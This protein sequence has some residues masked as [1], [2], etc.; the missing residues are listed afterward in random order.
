M[1]LSVVVGVT[2]LAIKFTAYFITGSS[3]IFSDALESIVNVLASLVALSAL[4]Y[5]HR[6]PDASHPYG[7]GKAEFLSAAFEGGMILLAS[8]VIVVTALGALLKGAAPQRLD[9]GLVLVSVA[10]LANG[11]VGLLLV[12]VGRRTGSITLEADGRH[13][14]ADAITS[15][16]ALAALLL[17]RLTGRGWID[18]LF[19]LLIGAYIA[20]Q[21]AGLV[22]RGLAGL[23]DQQDADDEQALVRLLDGHVAGTAPGICGFHKLR[24][25]HSGRYHWVDFHIQ[26]PAHWDIRRGHEVASAIEIEIE[27]LLG[28]GKATAHVEPCGRDDCPKCHETR[29]V[30]APSRP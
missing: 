29:V 21:G 14:L 13:L 4:T 19:A 27:Q 3:A 25:R 26:V 2:L 23:M 6:P 20:R 8:A 30:Q 5:A 7:H 9:I 1:L 12:N 10:T 18:P 11:G 28:E 24:H 22:R 15:V 17:V 16:A